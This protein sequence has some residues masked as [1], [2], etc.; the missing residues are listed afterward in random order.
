[1]WVY[2]LD[3]KTWNENVCSFVTKNIYHEKY[4]SRK[5]IIKKNVYHLQLQN[6]ITI[7]FI[8]LCQVDEN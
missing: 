2:F 6:N 5:Y 8:L 7:H 1:M 3:C 4:L